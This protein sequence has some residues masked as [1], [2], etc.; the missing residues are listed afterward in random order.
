VIR[1]YVFIPKDKV[2]KNDFERMLYLEAKEMTESNFDFKEDRDYKELRAKIG[3]EVERLE[4][5]KIESLEEK[6]DLYFNIF[7]KHFCYYPL[8][9]DLAVSLTKEIFTKLGYEVKA[10]K[11]KRLYHWF[12]E[13]TDVAT[14]LTWIFDPTAEQ[15]QEPFGDQYNSSRYEKN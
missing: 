7:K 9:C 8:Y 14:R 13:I 4:L 10:M 6:T 1:P 5:N 3:G 2:G 12:I 11:S 15:F